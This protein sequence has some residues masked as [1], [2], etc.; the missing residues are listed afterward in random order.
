MKQFFLYL[1]LFLSW[2]GVFSYIVAICFVALVPTQGYTSVFPWLTSLLT[3]AVSGLLGQFFFC[4]AVLS[5]VVSMILQNKERLPHL[6]APLQ[7]E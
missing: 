5:L 6:D 3:L 7:G 4:G 2:G 1:S